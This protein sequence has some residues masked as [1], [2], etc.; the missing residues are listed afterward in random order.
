VSE[1]GIYGFVR[2]LPIDTLNG[3]GAALALAAAVPVTR[4]YG[5]AYGVFILINLLRR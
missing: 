5:L 3:L 4:R 1:H 2:S